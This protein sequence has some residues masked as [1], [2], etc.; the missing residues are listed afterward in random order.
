M[1]PFFQI[2]NMLLCLLHRMARN[3]NKPGATRAAT[4]DISRL[5]TVFEMLVFIP[6]QIFGL[7]SSFLGSFGWFW[8]RSLHIL[9]FFNALFLDLNF[10][11][12]TLTTFLMMVSVILWST[13]MVLLFAVSAIRH[14]ICGNNLNRILYL[15]LIYKTLST[16]AGSGLL[17]LMVE[18]L[19]WLCLT[20]LITL[21]LLM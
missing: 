20:G 6:G 4:L 13:L 8:K 17:I 14:L 7:V 1:W 12:Y 2:C 15:N 11:Y 3:F 10:S 18:K 19:N 21:V 5:L 9:E 16:R